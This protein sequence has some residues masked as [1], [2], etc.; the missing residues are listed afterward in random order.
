MGRLFGGADPRLVRLEELA[1]LETSASAEARAFLHHQPHCT[2]C[3]DGRLA[4][5]PDGRD[6]LSLL[7]G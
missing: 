5:C 7:R 2:V 4:E 6:A 1:G 3:R